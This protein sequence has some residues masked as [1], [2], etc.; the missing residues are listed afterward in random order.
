MAVALYA[1]V[2]TVRQAEQD[3]SIPDQLNQ[4]REWCAAKGVLI[5]KEY[6]EPGASA[7][8]DR[9]PIFQEMI[10]DSTLNPAPFEAIIVH[11]LSR[12]FRDAI[13]FGVYERK[14]DKYGIKIISITQQT[15]EDASGQLA[16][17]VFSAFDEYQSQENSKHT[18]RAMK[19]NARRGFFNGSRAPFGF[20]AVE[21]EVLGNRGRRKRQ[22]AVDEAEAAIVRRIFDLYLDGYEGRRMGIKEIAKHLNARGQLMR[23]RPWA[24]QKV[25]KVLSDPVYRGEHYYNVIDARRGT[26]RPP[27]EWIPMKVEPIIDAETF[28]RV[29][30][31]R[32]DRRPT[33]VP[34]RVLS[35]PVLLTGLLRCG[36]CGAAMT[37]TTGKSGRYRYYKCSRRVNKG[38]AQCASRNLRMELLDELVLSQL[39][40]RVFTPAKLREILTLAR[41]Q[42]R[43]RTAADRQKLTLLQA[44]LRRAD[45]RLGRLYDAVESGLLPLDETLQKRVQQA[46]GGREAV[47]VE[48]ASLRR[49]EQLP[50][51]H[52]L[53]SQV[54]AFSKV[55]RAKLR[56]RASPFARDYLHAVVDS[57]VVHG[58]SATISGSHARL[59]GAIAGKKMGT[60]QVPTSIPD[61]RARRD[62]N[63]WPLPPEGS[64]LSS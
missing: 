5:A 18:S 19:E 2:S 64:A 11:S 21:T 10:T 39:E 22:L 62:S 45:E 47:L 53:P 16:R 17:R 40:G 59:M 32:A 41:R 13:S 57:V 46:K 23:G 44:E 50:V 33:A 34:P 61:W 49:L 37:L 29:R 55:V 48:M 30:Q 20:K 51:D 6:I 27:A 12:F 28:E 54:E 1:R 35:S 43:E 14:L 52:V 42:L 56:D 3:L 15:A 36:D 58:D 9:R 63:P 60:G 38:N 25:H 31:R 24:I 4:M 8:D 7:T 26:K